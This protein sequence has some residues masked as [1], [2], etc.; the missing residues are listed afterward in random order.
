MPPRG[1][2]LSHG[3]SLVGGFLFIIKVDNFLE[4]LTTPHSVCDPRPLSRSSLEFSLTATQF[5]FHHVPQCRDLQHPPDL[6]FPLHITS[7]LHQPDNWVSPSQRSSCV[8]ID[9][10][11]GFQPVRNTPSQPVHPSKRSL[12]P[13]HF[14][15]YQVDMASAVHVPSWSPNSARTLRGTIHT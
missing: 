9:F 11:C 4:I 2:H 3:I 6:L 7:G 5:L 13:H 8:A 12:N 15:D 10:E 14:H 1:Q